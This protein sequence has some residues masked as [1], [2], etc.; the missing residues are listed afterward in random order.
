MQKSLS[1]GECETICA[2]VSWLPFP[3]AGLSQDTI[4]NSLS[5][6]W[7]STLRKTF[8]F[9]ITATSVLVT[10]YQIL[11]P[12]C[13][14]LLLQKLCNLIKNIK[15]D[16]ISAL[17]LCENNNINALYPHLPKWSTYFCSF[18]RGFIKQ[19]V[20][21]HLSPQPRMKRLKLKTRRKRLKNRLFFGET[22]CS[23]VFVLSHFHAQRMGGFPI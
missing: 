6:Y 23:L 17:S 9:F 21:S 10:G 8:F 12:N 18:Q 22:L 5:T 15:M 16:F 14:F 7:H 2:R 11:P 1:C 3:Q 19:I 4:H 20:N 13:S